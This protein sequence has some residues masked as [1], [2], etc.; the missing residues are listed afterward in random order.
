M[1]QGKKIIQI[2]AR[3]LNG[4]IGAN[5]KLLWNIPEDLQLF[6]E[7]TL[8]H[9]VL[10][11]RKTSGSI[12]SKL[13]NRITIVVSSK[14]Y[15]H[16]NLTNEE[17]IIWSLDE[18]YSFSETLNSDKI[19]IVGGSQLYNSTFDI[20]DELW[21][22]QVEKEYPEADTYYH[23]PDGFKMIE[24]VYGDRCDEVGVGYSF[25]KWVRV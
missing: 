10:M 17:Q 14:N 22:T 3:G 4:E 25:Q 11:G 15:S 20:T 7:N 19:F 1:Y 2:V 12:P 9:V 23:I 16:Y 21:I 18:A 6:K 8:G 5:N 13:K 24:E